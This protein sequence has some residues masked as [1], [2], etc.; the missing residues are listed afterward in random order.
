MRYPDVPGKVKLRQ[1]RVRTGNYETPWIQD[2]E[3]DRGIFVHEI[4][5]GNGIHAENGSG[6]NGAH[7]AAENGGD[8]RN[9][10]F[11]HEEK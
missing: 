6:E 8:G 3:E 7:C 9:A 1:T 10:P 11:D 2:A 4:H 5:N